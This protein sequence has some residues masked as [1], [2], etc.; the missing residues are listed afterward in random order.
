MSLEKRCFVEIPEVFV[1]LSTLDIQNESVMQ[2]ADLDCHKTDETNVVQSDS[3]SQENNNNTNNNN[4]NANNT[5]TNNKHDGSSDYNSS[6]YSSEEDDSD[7]DISSSVNETV[8]NEQSIRFSHVIRYYQKIF[9]RHYAAVETN[10][11]S[12]VTSES[13]GEES[14]NEKYDPLFPKHDL[15]DGRLLYFVNLYILQH[16]TTS[17]S[18]F[19]NN[20][21][22]C[23]RSILDDSYEN[24][25]VNDL[26][27]NDLL[28]FISKFKALTSYKS[29][30][31]TLT[32]D[33]KPALVDVSIIITI[34]ILFT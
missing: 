4:D 29:N 7:G 14:S 15:W 8:S 26:N 20:L 16:G 28:Q 9:M 10:S 24:S 27:S 25:Y 22:Q 17:Y 23:Y 32:N 13:K 34:L 2:A 30:I 5:N 1:Y 21:P 19:Y 3:S 33:N 11:V 6:E 31:C 18:D 12:A